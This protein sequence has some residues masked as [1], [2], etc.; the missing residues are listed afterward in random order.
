MSWH[1][2]YKAEGGESLL[3]FPSAE[4]AIEAACSLADN[5]FQVLGIGARDHGASFAEIEIAR[6]YA[7]WARAKNPFGRISI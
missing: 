6:I 1:V 4:R 2:R 7:I 5:G 3:V